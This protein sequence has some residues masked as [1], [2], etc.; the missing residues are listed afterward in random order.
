MDFETYH[1]EK[2]I[3][4]AAFRAAEPARYAEWAAL[5]GAVSA[6]SFTQQ[7]KFLLNEVRRAY[8]LKP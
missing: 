7:K 2:N 6:E 3:D 5:F 1:R 4:P 8:L